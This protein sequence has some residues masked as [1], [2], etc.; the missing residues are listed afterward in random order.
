MN[1]RQTHQFL[2]APTSME[3]CLQNSHVRVV[4]HDFNHS[5]WEV[6][7][8]KSL[9][10]GLQNEF[11]DSQ[12]YK[13]KT[14]LKKSKQNNDPA[15]TPTTTSQGHSPNI[16]WMWYKRTEARQNRTWLPTHSCIVKGGSPATFGKRV[17][18]RTWLQEKEGGKA[19]HL[20]HWERNTK[21]SYFSPSSYQS[22]TSSTTQQ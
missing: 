5:T 15:P 17:F 13:E 19:E 16:C 4:A 2:H 10:S 6:K 21:W 11:L 3:G 7:A 9:E 18:F 8:D 1:T 22:V 14:C 12:S 20:C